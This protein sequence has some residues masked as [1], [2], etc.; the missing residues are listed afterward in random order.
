MYYCKINVDRECSGCMECVGERVFKCEECG[1]VVSDAD[2]WYRRMG[3]RLCD[4]CMR[5][6]RRTAK[7]VQMNWLL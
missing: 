3:R 5:D 2:G 4:G 1:A 7:Y 6:R